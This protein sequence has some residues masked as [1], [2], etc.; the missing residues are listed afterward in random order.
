MG[1]LDRL[2]S[3][4]GLGDSADH[5]RGTS[6]DSR[7]V[8]VT[9]EREPEPAPETEAAVKGA[10]AA[11]EDS[12]V[13]DDA[14]PTEEEEAATADEAAAETDGADDG[15]TA[16]EAAES[17]YS[18]EDVDVIKG[19]G[20]AYA[21]RLGEAGVDTVA[22]LATADADELAAETDLSAKRVSGWVEQA[23]NR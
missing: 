15:E 17:E 9:V 14:T 19:V 5:P 23:K 13:P 20:P 6:S 1:L 16:D 12:A 2:K 11:D 3:A 18:S 4:L 8:D 22:D 10:D 7:D 21:E